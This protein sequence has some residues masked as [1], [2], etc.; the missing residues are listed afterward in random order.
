MEARSIVAVG[1]YIHIYT[2]TNEYIFISRPEFNLSSLVR[3]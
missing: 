3:V 1:T 2:A